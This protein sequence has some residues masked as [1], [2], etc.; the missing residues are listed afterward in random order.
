MK[1][2]MERIP[3]EDRQ[4]KCAPVQPKP[5]D[6]RYE[7]GIRELEQMMEAMTFMNQIKLEQKYPMPY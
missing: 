3:L 5:K 6:D 4:G 1:K 7:R 2:L